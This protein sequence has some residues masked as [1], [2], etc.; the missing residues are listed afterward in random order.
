MAT[1]QYY[2]QPCADKFNNLNEMDKLLEI[3][4]LSK[5]TEEEK[6]WIFL[7]LLK[8]TPGPDCFTGEFSSRVHFKKGK[9]G[10]KNYGSASLINIDG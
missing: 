1:K 9:D 7:Y 5:L 10:T 4:Q 8:K 6:A 3:Y 2:K